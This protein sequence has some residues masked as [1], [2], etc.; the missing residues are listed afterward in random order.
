MG[1]DDDGHSH[2]IMIQVSV[3]QVNQ[4]QSPPGSKCPPL[5]QPGVNAPSPASASDSEPQR[6]EHRNQ[7]FPDPG[8]TPLRNPKAAQKQKS[9]SCG[10]P[11]QQTDDEQDTEG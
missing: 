3:I 9:H 7:Q 1:R 4:A 10:G 2:V 11:G 6:C 8:G 5:R